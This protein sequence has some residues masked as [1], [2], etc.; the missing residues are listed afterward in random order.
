M[1]CTLSTVYTFLQPNLIINLSMDVI[2]FLRS[3]PTRVGH[4]TIFY[5]RD[6]HNA[7]TRQLIRATGTR[8]VGK[9]LRCRG[10]NG[11]V[12]TNIHIM[13]EVTVLWPENMVT[14][15]QQCCRVPSSGTHYWCTYT[16]QYRELTKSTNKLRI[17]HYS[18]FYCTTF[19]LY[20][21]WYMYI[22]EN[23]RVSR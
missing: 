7:T 12:T 15:S 8:Q 13:Q 20:R 19:F 9:N 21:K 2:P 11:V 17:P 23:L 4:S 3:I 1:Y 6:N 18:T 5:L 16:V 22:L 10:L 14:L